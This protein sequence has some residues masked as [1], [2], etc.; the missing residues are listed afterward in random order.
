[1]DNLKKYWQLFSSAFYLSAFTFGGGYVIIPLMSNKFVD[2][3]GWIDKDEMM[4]MVAIA[5]SA[6]GS[7]AVNASIMIGYKVDGVVGA[8]ISVL[9]TIL[10]PLLLLS[11]ISLFYV[12]FKTNPYVNAVLGAM[13]AGVAAVIIDVVI[14]MG[15]QVFNDKN[16]VSIGIMILSFIAVYW[17][18]VNII[19]IILIAAIV[20]LM[21]K[22]T[23][24]V[25]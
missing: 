2:D 24:G 23:E 5:Q 17:F 3:L 9:G 6:P 16:V 15:K 20:G 4:D 14:K 19:Y 21:N 7:I 8:L 1:M 10:P 22:E 25:K 12:S 11:V 18:S 13:Q